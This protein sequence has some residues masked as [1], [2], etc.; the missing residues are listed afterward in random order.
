M[1][2]ESSLSQLQVP[3]TCPYF[4]HAQTSPHPPSHCLKIHLNIILPG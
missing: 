3:T 1:E 4:E 2:P